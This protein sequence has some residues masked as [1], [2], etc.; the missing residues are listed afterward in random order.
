LSSLGYSSARP[1]KA[2]PPVPE[3]VRV[4][5]VRGRIVYGATVL[6]SDLRSRESHER[7]ISFSQRRTRQR[8]SILFF[9]GVAAG[10]QAAL[11]ALLQQ[12]EIRTGTRGGHVHVV[13]IALPEKTKRRAAAR[14]PRG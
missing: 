4:S 7:L 13:P 14:A 12:L 10:D 6:H 3:I 8:S 5:P 1:G 9:I 2:R 11:E